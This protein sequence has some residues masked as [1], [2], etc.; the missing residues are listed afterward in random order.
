MYKYEFDNLMSDVIS[1]LRL[2]EAHITEKST[3]LSHLDHSLRKELYVDYDYQLLFRELTEQVSL[4]N[5][6][7]YK[8]VFASHYL[9]YQEDIPSAVHPSF[10]VIGPFAYTRYSE[11][12]IAKILQEAG[13]PNH[14]LKD[15]YAF[16]N[17]TTITPPVEIMSSLFDS[18]L[19]R[20]GVSN[21]MLRHISYKRSV[22]VDK[23]DDVISITPKST[24]EYTAIEA[25]YR[26]ESDLLVA[27]RNGDVKEAL[28]CSNHFMKF[29]LPPRVTDPLREAKDMVI[30][31]NTLLRKAVEDAYV[32]PLYIDDLNAKLT[33]EIEAI[34][35]I[36]DIGRVCQTVIR[37]Y[38]MLVQSYSRANYS[39]I[40]RDTLNY[41]DFHY[42]E[43]LSLSFFAER[44]SVTK[45]YLSAEFHKEVGM[46]LTDYI[47]GTRIRRALLL[48]NASKM[49]IEQIA[50]S[51]GFS[52]ANYF[53]RTF[54]K[55][56]GMSPSE[57]R[58]SLQ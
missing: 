58:K 28:R 26:V 11:E 52:D 54:K 27:V 36:A 40:I 16:L 44:F 57:Y 29:N 17:Q 45:N 42:E 15:L 38:C 43:P 7:I 53:T 8:D 55:H 20:Q 33:T 18:L 13:L 49:N 39:E 37:R 4:G 34:E 3:D 9:I 19:S 6:I 12:Y 23:K 41:T 1:A 56:Q 51:C 50:E 21:A 35:D 31:V 5:P 32:H 10:V 30:A 25:R 2:K 47:I 22:I 24:A 48:L 14:K 46:T